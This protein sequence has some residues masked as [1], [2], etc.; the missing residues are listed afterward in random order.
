MGAGYQSHSYK[1]RLGGHAAD[2]N[3][4]VPS[5]GG[6]TGASGAVAVIVFY[7]SVGII[8]RPWLRIIIL[9]IPIFLNIFSN[10]GQ[11]IRVAPLHAIIHDADCDIASANVIGGGIARSIDKCF[12][13][14]IFPNG[15]HIHI[16]ARD[17]AELVLKLEVP[18]LLHERVVGHRHFGDFGSQ[19]G[20]DIG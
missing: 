8:F 20:R 15:F 18:L 13:L 19:Q 11:Q 6:H 3:S 16:R 5:G 2:P 9:S 4:V 1:V 7:V 17:G 14:G 10:I 12:G